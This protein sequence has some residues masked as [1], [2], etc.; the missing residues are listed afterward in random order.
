MANAWVPATV[1]FMFRASSI[2]ERVVSDD[3]ARINLTHIEDLKYPIQ[4]QSPSR[5]LALYIARSK[6]FNHL[7]LLGLFVQLPLYFPNASVIITT[8]SGRP[9]VYIAG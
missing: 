7:I 2:Y 3:K 4:L 6:V 1:V 8:V 5:N 9:Q